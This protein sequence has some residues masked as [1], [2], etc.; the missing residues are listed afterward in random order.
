MVM[1]SAKTQRFKNVSRWEEKSNGT[2]LL[3]S[4]AISARILYSKAESA[5]QATVGE[6]LR[7]LRAVRCPPMA[8]S[9]VQ[10]IAAI[11]RPAC[12]RGHTLF[13]PSVLRRGP[14]AQTPACADRSRGCGR[15][16]PAGR[17]AAGRLEMKSDDGVLCSRLKSGGSSP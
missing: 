3:V 11:P 12:L 10:F 13:S 2:S 15:G 7:V 16:I 6:S 8:H 14:R 4:H 17:G 9:R 1:Q 5:L